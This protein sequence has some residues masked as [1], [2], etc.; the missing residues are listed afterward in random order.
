M[1]MRNGAGDCGVNGH[2]KVVRMEHDVD[3][4]NVAGVARAFCELV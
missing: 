1:M 3:M 2:C 4:T